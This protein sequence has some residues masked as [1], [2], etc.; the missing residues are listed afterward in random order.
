MTGWVA[1]ALLGGFV[2]LDT[3]SFPQAM[4][5]RPL[6]AGTLTGAVFGRPL[7]GLAVGFVMEAFSLLVLPIGAV[8]YPESG[9]ATVAATAAYLTSAA[10]PLDPSVLALVIAFALG[11]E[12]VGGASVVLQRRGNGRLLLARDGITA[13]ELE[14]RHLT[15]MTMDFLRGAVVAVSGGLLAT[16]GLQLVLPLWELSSRSTLAVLAVLTAG[17]IGTAVPLF[18]GVR[19]RRVALT[20]GLVVGLTLAMVLP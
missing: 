1:V 14:R 19:A 10:G 20:I 11:W 16:V 9:T 18:G 7:E 8:R 3:S 17:M 15:A 6:V 5:C 12:W 4:F 13:R 2:G